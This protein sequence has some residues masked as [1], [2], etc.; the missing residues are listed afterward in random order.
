MKVIIVGCGKVGS[1]LA[2]EL[3]NENHELTII[4]TDQARL[5]RTTD[6]IDAMGIVGD[7]VDYTILLDAGIQ[8]A[9]LL[10]AVTGSDEKNLLCCV[11]A[12]KA[13]HC[14][15]I[16][17]IRNPIYNEEQEF[18]RREFGI[19]MLINPSS[20]AADEI[21][22][23][24][25]YP[26]AE[27]VDSFVNGDVA[28]FHFTL[29]EDCVLVGKMIMDSSRII[30]SNAL[31]CTVQR[32][33][34]VFIPNGHFVLNAN[35]TVS[36]VVHRTEATEFFTEIGMMKNP[37]KDV[38]IAGGGDTAFYLAQLLLR[39]KN[40]KTYVKLIESDKDRCE[41]LA[42]KL[43]NATIIY[44][45]A[46]DRNLLSEEGLET[47]GGFA[48]LTGFDEENILLSLHAKK[49]SGAKTVT[50]VSRSSF[51]SLI[52]EM[53]IGSVVYPGQVTSQHILRFARAY[54]SGMD[55]EVE[56]LYKLADKKAEALEFKIKTDG[57]F[58]GVPIMEL[59]FKKNTLIACIYRDR[60]VIIPSGQDYLK[61]GD[62]VLV[63]IA[64]Y[65]VS[66]IEEIFI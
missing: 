7:G 36:V 2:E 55:S 24:F 18:L 63:V 28:L 11:V 37:V 51:N 30:K 64:G 50:G 54:N 58:L 59:K 57:S 25:K 5:H 13:G 12:R 26:F 16:A 38:I 47:A 32:D 1:S 61:T 31:V 10:I 52:S 49:V 40:Y 65:T 9:D 41:E 8:E 66:S 39:E 3:S 34:E 48:S 56:N 42:E 21:F 27:R 23:I 17:R 44:G 33:E 20:K 4:D 62:S 6:S 19:A 14:Q 15:T 43:P 60:K 29:N 46:T 22:S 53:K 45:D 35:D